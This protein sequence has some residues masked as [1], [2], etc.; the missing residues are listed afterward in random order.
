MLG[1]STKSIKEKGV[2]GAKEKLGI[3]GGW[4]VNPVKRASSMRS[5]DPDA[6]W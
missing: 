3:W 5:P 4:G 2:M 6:G 1:K